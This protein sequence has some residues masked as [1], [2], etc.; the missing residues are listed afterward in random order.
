[1]ITKQLR[2]DDDR[3]AALAELDA[4]LRSWTRITHR[5]APPATSIARRSLRRPPVLG[6]HPSPR[7]TWRSIHTAAHV[8]SSNRAGAAPDRRCTTMDVAA[9]VWC[10]RAAARCWS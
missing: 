2:A 10:A 6:G 7:S 8:L 3:V 5:L 9:R 1:R 4:N